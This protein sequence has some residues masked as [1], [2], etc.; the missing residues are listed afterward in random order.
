MPSYKTRLSD[1]ERT[2]ILAYLIS[3]KGVQ[4]P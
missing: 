1:Q 3:L 4:I 2:D